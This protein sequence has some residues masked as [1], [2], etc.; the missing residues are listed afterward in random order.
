MK[1]V[2]FPT[3]CDFNNYLER[4]ETI[5]MNLTYSIDVKETEA[6]ISRF[7]VENSELIEKNKRK[8][9]RFVIWVCMENK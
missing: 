6:E 2:D 8:V 7:K 9:V 3:L 4:V 1:R 5:V